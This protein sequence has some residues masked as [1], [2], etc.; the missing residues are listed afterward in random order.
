LYLLII[1]NRDIAAQALRQPRCVRASQRRRLLRQ[2]ILAVAKVRI[3][4]RIAV[5]DFIKMNVRKLPNVFERVSLGLCQNVVN[6]SLGLR[7]K[8]S[9]VDRRM[10][11]C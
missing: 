2:H 6:W 3:F 10:F 9:G 5:K 8:L 4:C 11:C 1:G 7:P